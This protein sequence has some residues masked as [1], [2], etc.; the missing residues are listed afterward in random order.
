L[1]YYNA[2]WYDAKLGRFLSADS[3]VPGPGNPQA[4]NRYAYVF[5]NPLRF[6]DPSGHDPVDYCGGNGACELI[7]LFAN[8]DNMFDTTGLVANWGRLRDEVWYE[9]QRPADLGVWTVDS[10][11]LTTDHVIITR[12]DYVQDIQSRPAYKAAVGEFQFKAA[13][14][15]GNTLPNVGF[16]ASSSQRFRLKEAAENDS[17]NAVEWYLGSHRYDFSVINVNPIQRQ[18]T[19]RVTVTNRSDW[20]S[21]TRDPAVLVPYFGRSLLPNRGGPKSTDTRL[22]NFLFKWFPG[23]QKTWG[24]RGVT[25]RQTYAWT[26]TIALPYS[27]PIKGPR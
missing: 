13:R 20:E 3:L 26:T 6:A 11:Y 27:D 15:F 19:V 10:W 9:E 8:L 18:A 14:Q 7:F 5:N 2:R 16:K 25:Y 24:T 22:S 12:S 4:F 1:S 23:L 21:A 17:Y